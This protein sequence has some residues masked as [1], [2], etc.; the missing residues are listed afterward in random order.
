MKRETYIAIQDIAMLCDLNNE[1]HKI[2]VSSK[3][4]VN[5]EFTFLS[6]LIF[7]FIVAWY[8]LSSMSNQYCHGT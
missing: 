3:K 2:N 5:L 7:I 4:R 8:V 6:I 1:R